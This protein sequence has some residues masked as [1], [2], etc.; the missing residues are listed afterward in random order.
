MHGILLA[1][2]IMVAISVVGMCLN[3]K[4]PSTKTFVIGWVCLAAALAFVVP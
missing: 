3:I 2:V 1:N 4:P